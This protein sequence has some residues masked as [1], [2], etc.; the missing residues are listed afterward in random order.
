MFQGVGHA[1]DLPLLFSLNNLN[2]SKITDFKDI[3]V[4]EQITTLWSNFAKYG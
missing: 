3:L 2:N 4:K 1:S